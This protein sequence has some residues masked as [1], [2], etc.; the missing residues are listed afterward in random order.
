M[1]KIMIKYKSTFNKTFWYEYTKTLEDGT[2]VEFETDRLEELETE[3]KKIDKEYGSENIRV[4]SDI[5]YD[6]IVDV[7]DSV[8]MENVTVATPT[9]VNNVYNTAFEKVFGGN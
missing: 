6:V 1:Y 8:D 7:A 9:D 2:I 3:I 4:V 5:T